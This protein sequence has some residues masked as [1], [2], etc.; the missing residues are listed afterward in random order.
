MATDVTIG[1]SGTLFVGEDKIV[2]LELL[3][4]ADPPLP[5]DMTGWVMVF[6]VRNKDNS[7]EPPIVSKT[8]VI[9]GAYSGVSRAANFQRAIV[10]LTDDDM[11][12]FRGSNLPTGAKTYRHSWKRMTDGAETVVARGPFSPEKATAP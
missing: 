8:P 9:S 10:T 3:D 7:P 5:V 6:D 2:R 1:G 11:N 12:L 4:K